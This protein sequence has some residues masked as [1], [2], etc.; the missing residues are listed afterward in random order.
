MGFRDPGLRPGLVCPAP[1]GRATLASRTWPRFRDSPREARESCR[2]HL[3]LDDALLP[4]D[5]V[6]CAAFVEEVFS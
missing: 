1:P 3:D 4:D 6:R 2:A 5:E